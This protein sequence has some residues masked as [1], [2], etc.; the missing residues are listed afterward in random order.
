MDTLTIPVFHVL[1]NFTSYLG[2]IIL[3]GINN[4]TRTFSFKKKKGPTRTLTNKG[5][6]KKL[7]RT[8]LN[9]PNFLVLH[10]NHMI[11]QLTSLVILKIYFP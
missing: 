5:T 11:W 1:V 10:L 9:I 6:V 2:F 4:S 8:M 3:H 7:L